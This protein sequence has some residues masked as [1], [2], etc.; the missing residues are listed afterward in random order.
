VEVQHGGDGEEEDVDVFDNVLNYCKR[1]V[2]D[3]MRG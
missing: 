1:G 2:R 3:M